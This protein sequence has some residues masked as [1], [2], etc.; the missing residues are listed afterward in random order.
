VLHPCCLRFSNEACSWGVAKIA[1]FGPGGA[2]QREQ[3]APEFGIPA[4]DP[5]DECDRGEEIRGVDPHAVVLHQ[6]PVVVGVE[7][8]GILRANAASLSQ[9]REGTHRSDSSNLY[10]RVLIGDAGRMPD[11]CKMVP[12]T[13]LPAL[14]QEHLS[15]ADEGRSR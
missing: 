14:R 9:N 1:G 7:R 2:G 15:G 10:G 12:A 3:L 13:A 11:H 5:S 8:D 4:F 6:H